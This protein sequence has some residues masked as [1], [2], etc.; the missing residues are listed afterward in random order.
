MGSA[1]LTPITAATDYNRGACSE[2]RISV[3]DLSSSGEV[4]PHAPV[5]LDVSPDNPATQLLDTMREIDKRAGEIT[6][7]F[8][9]ITTAL[10]DVSDPRRNRCFLSFRRNDLSKMKPLQCQWAEIYQL[11]KKTMWGSRDVAA[12]IA[13]KF[14]SK[15]LEPPSSVFLPT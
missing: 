6:A 15:L 3:S 10:K 4:K 12:I 9:A 8:V 1:Q 14:K 2:N 11:H 13:A 7:H 5:P